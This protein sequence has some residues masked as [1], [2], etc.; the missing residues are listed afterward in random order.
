M[1]TVYLLCWI[2]VVLG[3]A[4]GVPKVGCLQAILEISAL[5]IFYNS[6]RSTSYVVGAA[7]F[8]Q[9]LFMSRSSGSYGIPCHC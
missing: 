7:T 2:G 5:P 1:A 8:A 4:E 3:P 9:I 6:C